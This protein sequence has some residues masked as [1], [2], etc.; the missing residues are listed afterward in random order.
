MAK[1]KVALEHHIQ[2]RYHT[3][4]H[5]PGR[6]AAASY[7]RFGLRYS[8]ERGAPRLRVPL[9]TH[10][11][12]EALRLRS[13]KEAELNAVAVVESGGT[14]RAAALTYLADIKKGRK[15]KT[16]QA[17]TVALRY[18]I[19]AIGNKAMNK[20]TRHD[21]MDF[22]LYLREEKS[23]EPRSEWNKFGNV[24]SFLK[25][26]GVRGSDLKISKH[27]WPS[28]TEA[29]PEIY[30][31]EV[32]D[33]LFA[34]CDDEERLWFTFFLQTGMREQEAMHTDDKDVNFKTCEIRVTH[35]PEFD[36][37][38]KMYRERTINVP[39]QLVEDIKAML[40][41]RGKGGLLFGTS[42]GKPKFD[43]LDCLK[44]AATRAGLDPEDFWLHKFRATFATKALWKT[45]GDYGKVQK[46][47][48]HKDVKS[49]LRYVRSRRG[50]ELQD[51][52]ESIWA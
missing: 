46:W 43:F 13:E 10:D 41:E 6:R 52:V 5:G 38:P 7:G 4:S 18:F 50:V 40:V 19:E 23:Q 39:R 11:L 9:D 33:K 37:S 47:L 35:K 2:K 30:E 44:A 26:Q 22:R 49:T 48:G 36:W 28:F 20:I 1:L 12:A 17:Y 14:L 32:L 29:E 15:K 21:L 8:P 27:D 16:H 42:S 45:S 31:D 24:M 34:A 25:T 51:M 3:I